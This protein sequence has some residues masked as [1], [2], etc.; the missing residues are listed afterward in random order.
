MDSPSQVASFIAE[1]K[2]P[3]SP[4]IVAVAGASAS[5]K[6]TVSRKIV[7]ELE[8]RGLPVVRDPSGRAA[9][10]EMDMFYREDNKEISEV[11][12]G[13]FDHPMEID[14][15]ELERVLDSLVEGK[16]TEVPV[17]DFKTSRRTGYTG[18]LTP[19]ES[20]VIVVEG[21]YAVGLLSRRADLTI[22]VEADS[23]MELFARRLLRDVT[24]SG[25]RMEE[26]M[27]FVSTALAMWNVYG[28]SQRQYSDV[29]LRSH[30]S[31][32]EDRG[33][34]SYQVKVSESIFAEKLPS[35]WNKLRS[36][37]VVRAE[38]LVVG[39]VDEMMR[40]RLIFEG[41]RP[42]SFEVSYRKLVPSGLPYIRSLRIELSPSTYTAFVTLSQIMG[43]TP[44]VF[45][46]EIVVHSQDGVNFKWYPERET[47]EIESDRVD[48]IKGVI[49]KFRGHIRLRSYYASSFD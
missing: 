22:F 7:E 6:S 46:R 28:E 30:Y 25:Q 11:L 2:D 33:K 4:Y 10:I 42:A 14:V 26:I 40:G 47:V 38:D 23:R 8:R 32:L 37:Q 12:G 29:I 21:L 3:S 16:E 44:R 43:Y 35:T 9:V 15:R 17:Y 31:I 20:P 18:P 49:K 19:D 45:Y 36:G 27:K 24:R 34:P 39:G 1:V 13:N 5:G 41:G 48:K